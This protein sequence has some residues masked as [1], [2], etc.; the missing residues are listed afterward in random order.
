VEK[1][2]VKTVKKPA[3][4]TEI[5]GFFHLGQT[6]TIKATPGTAVVSKKQPPMS[7]KPRAM[8]P[9]T[10][11]PPAQPTAKKYT[12]DNYDDNISKIIIK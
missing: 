3:V 8:S 11:P 12:N 2:K 4:Q 1:K 6:S 5:T 10:A 9:T 7:L